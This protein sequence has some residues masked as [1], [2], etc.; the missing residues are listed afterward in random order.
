MHGV[1]AVSLLREYR[2]GISGRRAASCLLCLLM[3]SPASVP[4]FVGLRRIVVCL[5]GGD[6]SEDLRSLNEVM[7]L[8]GLPVLVTEEGVREVDHVDRELLRI[9]EEGNAMTVAVRELPQLT[10]D[11]TVLVVRVLESTTAGRS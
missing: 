2:R 6:E 10:T 4:L 3:S 11:P 1:S 5:H 7:V 8:L 9:L